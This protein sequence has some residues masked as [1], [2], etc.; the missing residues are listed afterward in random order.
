MRRRL[1]LFRIDNVIFIPLFLCVSQFLLTPTAAAA[2]VATTPLP[3]KHTPTSSSA[4]Q[5][6]DSSEN[7][8]RRSR[9]PLFPLTAVAYADLTV[10]DEL[11]VS[12]VANA[13]TTGKRVADVLLLLLSLYL[14]YMYD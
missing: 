9:I 1:S 3:S 13:L 10:L 8:K 4:S 7:I 2:A 12:T 11:A 5:S 14:L 6:N